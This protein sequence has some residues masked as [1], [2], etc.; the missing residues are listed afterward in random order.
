MDN[1]YEKS[2]TIDFPIEIK[3]TQYDEH[4]IT[5]HVPMVDVYF[6]AKTMEAFKHKAKALV[7][8]WIQHNLEHHM[9]GGNKK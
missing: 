8:I 5:G 7:T 4:T 1:T 9:K 2:I 3:Y 6:S